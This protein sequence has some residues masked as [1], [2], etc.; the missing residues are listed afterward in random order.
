[1]RRGNDSASLTKSPVAG[2]NSVGIARRDVVSE[3]SKLG[4]GGDGLF[5]VGLQARD[6]TWCS[7]RHFGSPLHATAAI[8]LRRVLRSQRMGEPATHG[9]QVRP[10]RREE[11]HQLVEAGVFLGKRVQLFRA[12]AFDRPS[13]RQIHR[14]RSPT[15]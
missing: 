10:L 5:D 9:P 11:Y 4:E 3:G 15:C 14:S 2:C 8:R 7:R 12:Y 13:L 6:A 1:M